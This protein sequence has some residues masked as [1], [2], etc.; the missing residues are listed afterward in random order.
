MFHRFSYISRLL[1]FSS[2]KTR[3]LVLS[4]KKTFVLS[5]SRQKTFVL[6]FSR[7]KT[8]VLSFSRQKTFVLSFS[9]Q[10]TF[11]LSSSRQKNF[12]SLVFSSKNSFSR[13]Y[14]SPRYSMISR[15]AWA[16]KNLAKRVWLQA[17]SA[18]CSSGQRRIQLFR[19]FSA[20]WA[21]LSGKYSRANSDLG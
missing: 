19:R 5:F 20:T 12:R 9:R 8:F 16:E 18:F 6:S 14:G 11:V 10:K 4:S 15:T 13:L 3:H 2:K 7:Q 21:S 17:M 1:V